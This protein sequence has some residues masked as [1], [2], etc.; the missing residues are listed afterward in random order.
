MLLIISIR[1]FLLFRP[2]TNNEKPVRI[3]LKQPTP[4]AEVGQLLQE[5]GI[6]SSPTLFL[7]LS[8]LQGARMIPAGSYQV[9]PSEDL[10]SLVKRFRRGLQ[11]TVKL[12]LGNERKR[13]RTPMQFGAKMEKYGYTLADSAQWMQFLTSNDSL[14]T[15][16]V[17][18]N[19][20]MTR[21][22][23]LTY[24][25]YWTQPPRTIY[26]LMNKAWEK[27]WN[28][29]RKEKARA[30]QLSPTE[31]QILASI[32]EEETQHGPDRPLVASTYLNRLRI[33]MR[34]QADP[35]AKF[36]SRDFEAKRV[37]F[38]HLR[39]ESPYNTYLHA[40]LPPGPICLPSIAA[41]D[42]VLNAPTTDHL[43]FVASHRFDGTS[44]FTKDY[45]VHLQNAR[46]YQQELD[47][48]TKNKSKSTR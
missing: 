25:V 33:G 28:A 15:F 37:L 48:R 6:C 5:K 21:L 47:K 18:T 34:L 14:A 30:L 38:S 10:Y 16:G 45:S 2:W 13:L 40:G 4:V 26:Q 27:F 12:T 9:P 8:R 36:G 20:V 32:V 3:Q 11:S 41:I 35:T 46:R 23:P 7:Y 44:V 22:L 42:A 43:Y 31:I 29:A 17:D 39:H 19:T 24:D 1:V